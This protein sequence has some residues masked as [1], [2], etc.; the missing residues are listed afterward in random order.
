MS[1]ARTY[2][3]ADIRDRIDSLRPIFHLLPEEVVAALDAGKLDLASQLAQ[4]AF[5]ELYFEPLPSLPQSV[6][7]GM[8]LY[9]KASL[10]ALE[11]VK[12]AEPQAYCDYYEL[13]TPSRVAGALEHER[14]Y[15]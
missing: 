9:R 2:T 6:L 13:Y 5:S 15:C 12:Y 1:A 4:R 3:T 7:R 10:D 8:W 11:A 14:R